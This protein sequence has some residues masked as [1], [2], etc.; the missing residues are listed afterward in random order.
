LGASKP[1]EGTASPANSS[2]IGRRIYEAL[3]LLPEADWS[4]GVQAMGKA[5]FLFQSS[6]AELLQATP[7]RKPGII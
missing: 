5:I 3:H 7:T 6:L 2:K 4:R 1:I